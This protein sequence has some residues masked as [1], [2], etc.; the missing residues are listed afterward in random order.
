MRRAKASLTRHAARSGIKFEVVVVDDASPDGTQDVARALAALYGEDVVVLRPR[1][2][3]LGLGAPRLS[4]HAAHA[5]VLRQ[6]RCAT[7]GADA[8][9]APAAGTA[10][11]HGLKHARGDRI[12]IMDADMS[13]HVRGIAAALLQRR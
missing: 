3:K 13:H 5:T 7:P 9:S 10:Y 6:P 4:R 12:V 1:P 11:L 2:G 8:A